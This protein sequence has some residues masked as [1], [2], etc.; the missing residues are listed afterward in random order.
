MKTTQPQSLVF[1]PFKRHQPPLET[2]A[3]ESSMLGPKGVEFSDTRGIKPVAAA[4]IS[5]FAKSRK[6]A[7]NNNEQAATSSANKETISDSNNMSSQ[8]SSSRIQNV[9]NSIIQNKNQKRSDDSGWPENNKS[10]S[11]NSD[12]MSSNSN[13]NSINNNNNNSNN[14]DDDSDDDNEQRNTNSATSSSVLIKVSS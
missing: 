14:D 7:N 1:H 9:A 13:S 3:V 5:P 4:V 10:E 8:S 11:V 2:V 12:S 6:F